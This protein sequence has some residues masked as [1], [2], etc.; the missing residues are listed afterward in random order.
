MSITIAS[1]ISEFTQFLKRYVRVELEEKIVCQCQHDSEYAVAYSQ[2]EKI[3]PILLL[4]S[5]R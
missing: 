5:T 3:L 4:L 1:Q 2:R